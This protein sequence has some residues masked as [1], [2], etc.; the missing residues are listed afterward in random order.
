MAE[1][2]RDRWGRYKLPHPE[3][4]ESRGWTRVTKLADT[5]EDS[6]GLPGWQKRDVASGIGKRLDRADLASAPELDDWEQRGDV[7][8]QAT[9]AAKADMGA[10]QGAAL[11]KFTERID[12]GEP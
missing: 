1:P 3:T 12:R 8:R 2:E 11:H 5:L 9:A 4:G 10:N 6:Y 7:V